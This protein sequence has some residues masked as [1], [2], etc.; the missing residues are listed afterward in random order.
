[1]KSYVSLTRNWNPV[2]PH[3]PTPVFGPF[4]APIHHADWHEAMLTTP[5]TNWTRLDNGVRVVTEQVDNCVSA[6]ISVIVDAG[7]QDEVPGKIGLAHLCEHAAFLGTPLRSSRDLALLIDAAGGCFGAFT[8]PD[9]TCFYSHVLKE[10]VSYAF[11][12]MGDILVAS[13]YPEECLER[14]KDVI[15]QE[16]IGYQD[17]SDSILLD[18]TKQ[19]LWPDD[20]LS[21]SVIGSI[22][23]VRGLNRS[24]VIQFVSRQYTP[25]RL[26]VAAAGGIEHEEVVEQVQ[27]AFWTLRGQSTP[28][29]NTPPEIK[30]GVSI[31]T[32][33]TAQCSFSVAIPTPPFADENRYTLHVMNNLIGGGMS[34]RLYQT[35]RE[36]HGLVYSVQSSVLSYRRGGALIISGATSADQLIQ[37]VTLVLMQLM[38]LAMWESPIDEEEL[39]KSKMQVRSQSRLATDMISNRVSRIATQ[40]FHL[41]TRIDD[42]KILEDIDSVTIEDLQKLAFEVLLNGMK[43]LSIAVVGPVQP[44]GA[45]YD[46]LIDIHSSFAGSA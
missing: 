6:G 18:L 12:L 11:D 24:D 41:N 38:S 23:D 1:M 31:H 5:K 27:D 40:E 21:N 3:G 39:W 33:P 2:D 7:P 20:T 35:L 28:R 13:K 14:E 30:G 29:S 45:T 42:E 10:Y 17:S 44:D 22:E 9:Y 34:S 36:T 26:I 8:A 4:L 37:G 46:D 43:H 15:C 16:I 32:M 19:N 25:D